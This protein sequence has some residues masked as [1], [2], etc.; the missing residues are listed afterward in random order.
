MV[1]TDD[2]QVGAENALILAVSAG[3]VF[4]AEKGDIYEAGVAFPLLQAVQTV[5]ERL[6]Q[7]DLSVLER[8][9]V[10]LVS[11]NRLLQQQ[12]D[13][14]QNSVTAH[15]LQIHHFSFSCED[16]FTE[17]LRQNK[18]HLFITTDSNEAKQAANEGVLSAVLDPLLASGPSDQLR[19]LFYADVLDPSSGPRTLTHQ[20]AQIF[21][22]GLGKI[23][24]RFGVLD[25]PISLVLL[26]VHGGTNHSC[27]VLKLLRTD[28]VDVD[29]VYCL[30]GSPQG[31]ILPLLRH[32]FLLKATKE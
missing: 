26:I 6:L 27:S 21:G 28:G 29:E 1:E 30:G 14:L 2:S 23:R 17:S 5:N 9:K 10:F 15:G 31:A 3:A 13:R 4:G 11:T 7:V 24:Q 12:K 8:F 16:N 20:A 25:S 18:V 22:S 32:H 19:V